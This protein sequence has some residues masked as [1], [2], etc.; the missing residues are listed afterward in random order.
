MGDTHLYNVLGVSRNASSSEIKKAYHRM[1]K[2]YHPDKNPESAEKFKEIR[3]AYD[4]LSNPEKKEIY[5]N[6]GMQGLADGFSPGGPGFPFGD[7]LGGMFGMRGGFMGSRHR[8]QRGDDTTHHLRVTLEDFYNGKTAKL[9]LSRT[10]LCKACGGAGGRGNVLTCRMCHGHGIKKTMR[11]LG[12][13]MMQEIQ[14]TCPECRGEGESYSDKDKCVPCMG[15]KVVNEDKILEVH[16]DKGMRDGQKIL[17]RGEGDQLPDVDP[18]DVIIILTQIEHKKFV[19]NGEDLYYKHTL[20]LTEALCGFEMVLKHLDKR[21]L[22]IKSEPG[23][24]F[25]PG[26]RKVIKEEGMPVYRNTFERGDLIIE[27]NIKFPPPHFIGEPEL[28]E[29]EKLLPEPSQVSVP[30]DDDTVEE[31]TLVEMSASRR[32]N[33]RSEAYEEDHDHFNHRGSGGAHMQC[34]HQ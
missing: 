12:P 33:R 31:V 19:R 1:A 8:R 27:F 23:E 10:V 32:N 17:F 6:F 34:A 2:E 22:L 11:Q 25:R 16:V 3:N 29:L 15:R 21:Q 4:I 28:K 7:V 13:G 26:A 5:D 14:T 30:M 18:G 24:V 9:Q 20:G